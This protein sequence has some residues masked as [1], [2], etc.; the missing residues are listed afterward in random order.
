MKE[1]NLKMKQFKIMTIIVEILGM[2][3]A[4]TGIAFTVFTNDM[5]MET[6]GE[7]VFFIIYLAL[8]IYCCV[9]F[10]GTIYRKS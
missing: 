6:I 4:L 10:V 1:R 2:L 8:Y 3:L 9:C 7:I 5:G